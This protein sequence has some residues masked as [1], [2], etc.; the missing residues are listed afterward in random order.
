MGV[1]STNGLGLPSLNEQLKICARLLS[2]REKQND[3]EGIFRAHFRM[4][5]IFEKLKNPEEAKRCYQNSLEVSLSPIYKIEAYFQL[6]NL[7]WI[8]GNYAESIELLRQ[9]L[10]LRETN[11]DDIS[12]TWKSMANLVGKFE[13][14][15][16]FLN[17][18][19]IYLKM[20]EFAHAYERN[21]SINILDVMYGL[22]NSLWEL[23]DVDMA[24]DLLRKELDLQARG[25]N[26]EKH[27]RSKLNFARF[28]YATGNC[29]EAEALLLDLL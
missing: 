17:A 27:K 1:I 16:D 3:S 11:S 23:G 5:I 13:S 7:M 8:L 21:P 9:E 2:I 18:K 26:V 15:R 24:S 6:G 29:S 22:G 25:K 10:E 4:A 20:L 28:L 14:R 12:R 19:N